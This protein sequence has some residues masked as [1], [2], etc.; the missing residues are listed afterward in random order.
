MHKKV[1][2][3]WPKGP[4]YVTLGGGGGCRGQSYKALHGGGGYLA[5]RYVTLIFYF[6]CLVATSDENAL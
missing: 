5:D 2:H 1:E 3:T 6:T 4:K